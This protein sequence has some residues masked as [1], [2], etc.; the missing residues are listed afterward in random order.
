MKRFWIAAVAVAFAAASFAA[1]GLAAPAG[2]HP[3]STPTAAS[4]TPKRPKLP[5]LPSAVKKRKKW[6]IGVKCDFPPFGFIDVRGHNAGYDVEVARR[7][8]QLAFLSKK[9]VELVCVTTPS[10]IPTLTS[11][12][13]D[14]IISTL[15]W[16]AARAEVI[17][18]SIPYYSATGRLLVPNNSSIHSVSD[19][20]GKTIVTTRGAL[21]ATWTRNC[22]KDSDLLEVDSPSAATL[23]V[24]NGQAA[25]FMFDDAFLLGVATQDPTLKL[26]NDKFLNIPW[27]IGIR[28]GDTAMARWVNA[29]IRYMKKKDEFAKILRNNAPARLIPSFLGNVPRPRNSF[30]YPVGKDPTSDCSSK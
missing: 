27:G 30:A 23:A 10:R 2:T 9:K 25:T 14:I 15:T 19:L 20:K 17:D 29:A 4:T 24:K 6:E 16:T 5:P 12:R 11:G 21:Y 7:F 3:S 28:K 8:A 22:F 1:W 13:V 26:T 18:Y